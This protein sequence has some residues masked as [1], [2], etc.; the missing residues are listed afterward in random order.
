[1]IPPLPFRLF[2]AILCGGLPAAIT[3]A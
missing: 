3:S 1:M 2:G